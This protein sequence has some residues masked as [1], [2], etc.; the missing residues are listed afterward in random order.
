MNTVE[1]PRNVR[2][3]KLSKIDRISELVEEGLDAIFLCIGGHE[4]SV[5]AAEIFQ[6]K[7][8][9]T[10]YLYLGLFE[11]DKMS[12]RAQL[13]ALG[14]IAQVPLLAVVIQEKEADYYSEVLNRLSQVREEPFVVS[15]SWIEIEDH[16]KEQMESRR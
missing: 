11:L 12:E 8:F 1:I 4:R 7:G 9:K 10:R 3:L 16:F 13:E 6:R 5:N 2:R 15:E 14:L